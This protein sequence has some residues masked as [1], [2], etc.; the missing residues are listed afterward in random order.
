MR[1]TGDLKIVQSLFYAAFLKGV[2]EFSQYEPF[3]RMMVDSPPRLPVT[4][5]AAVT[6]LV[7]PG[8]AVAAVGTVI[9]T[10]AVV[11]GG[12]QQAHWPSEGHT[13]GE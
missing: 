13:A 4:V 8:R 6:G 7:T 12:G 3:P 11:P 2:E 5:V 10:M 9:L 1:P